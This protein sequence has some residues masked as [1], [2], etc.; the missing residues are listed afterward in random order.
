M[1][2]WQYIAATRQFG[3][4]WVLSGL[5]TEPTPEAIRHGHDLAQ[6]LNDLGDDGW[7]LVTAVADQLI[8][9]RPA[10]DVVDAVVEEVD[11]A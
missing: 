10:A 9:K 1:A 11:N 3:S 7:E 8:F 6:I 4:G 2:K 5:R